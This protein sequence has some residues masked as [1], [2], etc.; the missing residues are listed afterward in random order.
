MPLARN[1][2]NRPSGRPLRPL[3]ACVLAALLVAGAARAASLGQ[4]PPLSGGS[5]PTL[6]TAEARAVAA[7]AY[8]WGWPLAYVHQ[9][10]V[11]LER[12]PYPGRSGGMPVAPL[13]R[14]AMLTDRATHRL[15]G[16]VCP[17]QDVF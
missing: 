11:A 4:A 12:V 5:E 3:Q 2:A 16:V 17:N 10:R 6:D 14:L 7:E 9:V 1:N 15:R 8:V 13:N